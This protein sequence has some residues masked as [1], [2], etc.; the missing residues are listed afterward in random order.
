LSLLTEMAVQVSDIIYFSDLL[1]PSKKNLIRPKTKVAKPAEIPLDVFFKMSQAE[2]SD[3]ISA[4]DEY[5]R[6]RD[7][8]MVTSPGYAS[9]IVKRFCAKLPFKFKVYINDLIT[10]DSLK[11]YNDWYD[12]HGPSARYPSTM[13]RLK[14][15]GNLNLQP[16]PDYISFIVNTDHEPQDPLTPFIIGHR[17]AHY[18]DSGYLREHYFYT[19]G[20][21]RILAN[22]IHSHSKDMLGV[23]IDRERIY[24]H[25]TLKG[26]INRLGEGT[27]QLSYNPFVEKMVGKIGRL[28][29]DDG[30]EVLRNIFAQYC[31]LGTTVFRHPKTNQRYTDLEQRV[32]EFC[33]KEMESLIGCEPFDL[34]KD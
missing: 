18:L 23:Q 13:E 1:D 7:T 16:T 34:M 22:F 24:D 14:E 31:V 29:K 26:E 25:N 10:R 28:A 5:Q 12:K 9:A 3:V 15:F 2:T 30:D 27:S 32:N 11:N 17:I 33:F 21:G 20:I 8:G 4:T 6:Y 19:K